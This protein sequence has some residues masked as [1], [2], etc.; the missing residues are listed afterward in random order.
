MGWRASGPLAA[1]FPASLIFGHRCMAEMASGPVLAVAVWLWFYTDRKRMFLA[2]LLTSVAI[3]LRYQNGL[4][5]VGLPIALLV[6]SAR[7]REAITF[8]AGGAVGLFAGEILD[9]ITWGHPFHSLLAYVR[10]NLLQG[11]SAAYGVSSWSYYL[12]T[13]WT[14]TGVSSLAIAVGVIA[15]WGRARALVAVA[16]GFVLVHCIVPHKEYRFL[17]A[18]IPLLLALSAVGLQTVLTRLTL[19]WRVDPSSAGNRRRCYLAGAVV[20]VAMSALM[21]VKAVDATLAS[22]GQWSDRVEGE[23]SVWHHGEGVNLALAETGNRSDLCGVL[24][25]VARRGLVGWTMYLLS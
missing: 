14:S 13:A 6:S 8:V 18:V 3:F 16:V 9:W 4:V 22:T 1:T 7:R 12:E 11:K 10:Y 21:V 23:M 15:A 19:G 20:G 17:M 25:A 5:A 2:G 24:L